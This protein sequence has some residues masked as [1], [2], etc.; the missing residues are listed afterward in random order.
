MRSKEEASQAG[1]R[2]PPQRRS[3]PEAWTGREEYHD[4][5]IPE[6]FRKQREDFREPP[7]AFREPPEV[8][9]ERPGRREGSR[10]IPRSRSEGFNSG[11]GASRDDAENPRTA[12]Y[13]RS[14][15]SKR[16]E[17][18]S[19][20]ADAFAAA[21]ESDDG[22][23]TSPGSGAGTPA[24]RSA[25]A[26]E[27]SG[28]PSRPGAGA[29]P[30][31]P[32]ASTTGPSSPPRGKRPSDSEP[33]ASAQEGGAGAGPGGAGNAEPRGAGGAGNESKSEKPSPDDGE[34]KRAVGS[35]VAPS[36]EVVGIIATIDKELDGTRGK[37]LEWRRR[38]FRE[39]MLRW[40]PD[41]NRKESPEQAAE[42]FRHVMA[43]RGG[44]LDA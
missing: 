43:R 36:P 8:E 32:R 17:A 29:S 33:D 28:S 26:S 4:A 39:L 40:H 34:A 30:S 6:P 20:A 24:G 37:D 3:V 41:K 14:Q 18:A 10:G 27:A 31:R 38:H 35:A 19:A 7:D 25:G 13:G 5:E 15:T 44:Y 21:G 42:V 16:R 1:R 22:S 2:S 11:R 12:K 23:P 9:A